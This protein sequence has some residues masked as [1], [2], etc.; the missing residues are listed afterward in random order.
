MRDR[1]IRIQKEEI[2]ANVKAIEELKDQNLKLATTIHKYNHR[3]SALENS[4]VKV[5]NNSNSKFA[6]ELSVTLNQIQKVTKQFAEET[7]T[8]IR[9]PSTNVVAVDNMIE[10]MRSEAINCGIDFSF[11]LCDSINPLLKEYI[12]EDK[13]ETL[14]GDHI[15]DAIIAINAKQDGYKSIMILIG[16]VQ[17]AYELSVYDT[18]VEFDISTLLKLGIEPITTHKENGGSGLGFMTTFETL[19][20]SKASLV[21]EEYDANVTNY[22]K[23]VTIRFDNKNEYRIYSYRAKEIEKVCNRR[24]IIIKKI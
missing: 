5:M 21:I 18:G 24:D 6:K 23:S 19:K 15:K 1:T 17:G 12:A 9:L 3:L 2:D 22:T 11:K 14:L 7:K 8:N 4:I 13:F 20:S 16:I 10:Y